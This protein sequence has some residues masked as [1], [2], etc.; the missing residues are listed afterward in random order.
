LRPGTLRPERAQADE[1]FARRKAGLR[2]F[3]HALKGSAATVSAVRL[4][5]V[6]LEMETAAAA[7]G[8][9]RFGELLPQAAEEFD[10][11]DGELALAGWR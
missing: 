9:E 6:A 11:F 5:A 1:E 3:A 8:L 2:R 7:G 4:S 10:R